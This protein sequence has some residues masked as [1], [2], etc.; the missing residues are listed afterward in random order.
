[1]SNDKPK[2][3]YIDDEQD[4]LVVFKSAF[5]RIYDVYTATSAL[6]GLKTLENEE[7]PIIITDQRMPKMTGVEFLKNLPDEPDNIRMILTGF[8]DIDAIIEAINTG[9]VYRYITKP[10]DKEELKITIDKALETLQ[11]RNRNKSLIIELKNANENLEGKVAERTKEVNQQKQE[12]EKLLLNI[13]PVETAEELKKYGKAKA[14]RFEEVTVMFSDI[15]DF[16]RITEKMD[17]EELVAE[18]D[19]C[20]S[21][22]DRI[23][24]K[25]GVEK[26]KTIGDA[27]MCCSGLPVP[28][29][30]HAKRVIEAAIEIQKFMDKMKKERTKSGKSYFELRIGIHSGPVVAGV[31]GLNKFAY[32]IWG[33]TVNTAARMEECSEPGKINISGDTKAIINGK[34]QITYRGKMEAKNKGQVDMY[35]IN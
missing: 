30:D 1:M 7:I 22:F 3:L 27:Y 10:W 18:I 15:K 35:F 23:I 16:T 2:I 21:E 19:F 25:H 34:F 32:D 11:L 14:R 26:I 6:E 4:N 17:P 12:I 5:R 29:K 28:Q 13:L 33:D 8:S 31:V 20:Y 24:Q 9:K